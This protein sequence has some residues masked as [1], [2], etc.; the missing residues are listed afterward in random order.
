LNISKITNAEAIALLTIIMANK[1]I[2]SLPEI[3]ISSTG[4]SAWLNTLYI[5]IIAFVFVLV[6]SKLM[7]TFPDFDILD[8]SE[9][10]GGKL[11][12][13]ITGIT[14]V[15][16]LILIANIVLRS[17]SY[18]LKTIYFKQSPILFIVLLMV[19]PIVIANKLGIKSIS[20]ICLYIMPLAYVGLIILLLA[21]ASDFEFQRIFPLLGYGLDATFFSGISNLFALSG[22]GYIFLLPP[23]LKENTQLKKI[24]LISL[25]FS[26]I[27]LFFS[28]LCMLF[29]FSF[30]IN[31]NENMTLYLLTMVVHHGNVIHGINIIFMLVWI[32]SIIA[33]VSTTIF[34]VLLILRKLGNIDNISPVNYSISMLLLSSSIIFQNYPQFFSTVQNLLIKVVLYFVFIF[35]PLLLLFSNVKHKFKSHRMSIIRKEQS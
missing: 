4:S 3:I 28:I 14:Q 24:T 15:I 6:V 17:F 27:A 12:K 16:I 30:H 9:Y 7:K 29:I 32:L 11:L 25:T 13:W 20:K 10:V 5:I 33:Y 26:S 22:L 21:P 19:F 8:V 1:I 35:E 18:T 2:L 23:I 31:T 34:F